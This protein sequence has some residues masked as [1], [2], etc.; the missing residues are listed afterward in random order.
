MPTLSWSDTAYFLRFYNLIYFYWFVLPRIC[1]LYVLLAC[2]GTLCIHSPGRQPHLCGKCSSTR[3][4]PYT[5]TSRP[6]GRLHWRGKSAHWR[7]EQHLWDKETSVPFWDLWWNQ[8]VWTVRKVYYLGHL[9]IKLLDILRLLSLCVCHVISV[10]D[11][12][13]VRHQNTYDNNVKVI[14]MIRLFAFGVGLKR[15]HKD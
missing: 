12:H 8:S 5:H 3:L 9:Q 11:T 15:S 6:L 4:L 7:H 1:L 10:S 14:T 2:T 13:R